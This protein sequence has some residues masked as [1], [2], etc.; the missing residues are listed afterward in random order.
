MYTFIFPHI[1]LYVTS[2]LLN[3]ANMSARSKKG[4][5]LVTQRRNHVCITLQHK[6]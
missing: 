3:I 1:A 2:I 5:K 4:D 6:T